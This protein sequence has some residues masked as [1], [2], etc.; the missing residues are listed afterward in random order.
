MAKTFETRPV[1]IRDDL[2]LGIKAIIV[3]YARAHSTYLGLA[4]PEFKKLSMVG[5]KPTKE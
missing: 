2:S 4:K 1:F 5:V 3:R